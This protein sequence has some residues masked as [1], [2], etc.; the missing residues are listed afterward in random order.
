M[1]KVNYNQLRENLFKQTP[2]QVAPLALQTAR[3]KFSGAKDEMLEDFDNHPVT[4]E[5]EAGKENGL[6]ASNISGTLGGKGN[7]WGFIGFSQ[8]SDPIGDIRNE[9]KASYLTETPKIKK[10]GNRMLFNYSVKYPDL[11]DL[12][13]L[14]SA[15]MEWENRTWFEAVETFIS[16]LSNYVRHKVTG[17]SGAGLQ[18][19]NPLRDAV[20]SPVKYLSV[21]LKDFKERFNN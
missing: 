4:Q 14:S 3:N 13:K 20:Y 5:I 11:K 17:R 21:I 16:G 12:S 18:A 8:G 9:L 1:A 7:L 15:K 2:K 19:K 6:N 10:E